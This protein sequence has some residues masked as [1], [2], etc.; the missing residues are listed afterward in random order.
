[1]WSR[2]SCLRELSKAYEVPWLHHQEGSVFVLSTIERALEEGTCMSRWQ[3]DPG[4]IHGLVRWHAVLGACFLLRGKE[5]AKLASCWAG[6]R[7]DPLGPP[8]MGF[9]PG[10]LPKGAVSSRLLGS[11]VEFRFG[12]AKVYIHSGF[13]LQVFSDWV[14]KLLFETFLICVLLA[15]NIMKKVL[16]IL[17]IKVGSLLLASFR[18][19]NEVEAVPC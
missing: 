16:L 8:W 1:M 3:C 18:S 15:L 14:L 4:T 2:V 19:S 17:D 10:F 9:F 11:F 12:Q 5:P 7:S 13:F 6:A